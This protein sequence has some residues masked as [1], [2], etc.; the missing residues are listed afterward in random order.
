MPKG[1]AD[2][3]GL[4]LPEQIWKEVIYE[5]IREALRPPS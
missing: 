4:K 3:L 2:A 5:R 1:E